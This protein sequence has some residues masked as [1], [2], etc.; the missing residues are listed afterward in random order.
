MPGPKEA[1]KTCTGH[2]FQWPLQGPLSALFAGLPITENF[3]RSHTLNPVPCPAQAGQMAQPGE[4]PGWTQ[5]IPQF[6]A[7]LKRL[8]RRKE[9][10][11]LHPSWTS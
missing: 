8:H 2:P 9:H 10:L 1:E 11:H 5:P 7:A 4:T 3:L 6:S